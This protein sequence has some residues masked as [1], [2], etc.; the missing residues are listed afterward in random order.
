MTEPTPGKRKRGRPPLAASFDFTE[1]WAK[2][3][4][5]ERAA[6]I[7]AAKPKTIGRPRL[8]TIGKSRGGQIHRVPVEHVAQ[9]ADEI[10]AE[11]PAMTRRDALWTALLEMLAD[12]NVPERGAR[13]VLDNICRLD[14]MRRKIPAK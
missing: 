2:R 7:E 4:Y 9:A 1:W 14:R 3:I 6:A 10:T 11:S 5:A 12:R 8:A 13:T